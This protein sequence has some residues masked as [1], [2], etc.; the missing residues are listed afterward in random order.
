MK[1][2]LFLII[3]VL[4]LSATA[5]SQ[6]TLTKKQWKKQQ[7]SFLLPGRP[8]TVEVPLWI[9]GFAGSFAYGDIDI[10]G[11]DGVDPEHPVEP[12]PGGG[13]GEIIS[14]IFTK[15]WYLKFFFLTK[16]SYE[17]KKF[18]VVFDAISGAVG[19]STKFKYNDKEIVQANFRTTNMRLFTGYKLV[20]VTSENKNFRYELFGYLGVRAYFQDIF[21][22]LNGAINKLDIHPFWIEPIF[23]LQNQFTFKRWFIIIQGDYGG[24]FIDTKS[25]VQFTGFVYFRSGRI[26]SIKLGWNHLEMKHHGTL[27]KQEYKA[28]VTLSGPSMGIV[29][30]F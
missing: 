5:F 30:H 17:K 25:S 7:K 26:T 14:R 6:D 24:L 16:I 19:Y 29:F 15:E 21:S 4:L 13:V 27:L 8:W 3:S 22:D 2:Y 1:K 23:G 9:P 20:Q 12:P 28:R 11:E 18:E 10:E